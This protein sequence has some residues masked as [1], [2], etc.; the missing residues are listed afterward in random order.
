MNPYDNLLG[1]IMAGMPK[2]DIAPATVEQRRRRLE[3]SLAMWGD[4]ADTRARQARTA[5][6][7]DRMRVEDELERGCETAFEIRDPMSDDRNIAWNAWIS[8]WQTT[9]DPNEIRWLVQEVLAVAE[10]EPKAPP[11]QDSEARERLLK[12]TVQLVESVCEGVEHTRE[13][14]AARAR[15]F[16]TFSRLA[17]ATAKVNSIDAQ[18][19]YDKYLS[20]GERRIIEAVEAGDS[21]ARSE[22]VIEQVHTVAFIGNY[23][24][25]PNKEIFDSRRFSKNNNLPAGNP[26]TRALMRDMAAIVPVY[27][28]IGT[29]DED[30][31]GCS[32]SFRIWAEHRAED[33]GTTVYCGLDAKTGA[34]MAYDDDGSNPRPPEQVAIDPEPGSPVFVKIVP[35]A[36]PHDIESK[37]R[38]TTALGKG[39]Y[40]ATKADMHS[41]VTACAA[42]LGGPR[43]VHVMLSEKGQSDL[44]HERRSTRVGKKTT[45]PPQIS[46]AHHC[47][48][49]GLSLAGHP[50]DYTFGAPLPAKDR[51][52][53]ETGE[54]L[55]GQGSGN[56]MD[57]VKFTWVALGRESSGKSLI[58]GRT[59]H[60]LAALETRDAE[61]RWLNGAESRVPQV[62]PM[63][64]RGD[65]VVTL[66][67]T[68]VPKT[69]PAWQVALIA[70]RAK[71]S[72]IRSC[73]N[74][75]VNAARGENTEWVD[76]ERHARVRILIDQESFANSA[77]MER[78]RKVM[79]VINSPQTRT[80]EPEVYLEV[81][82]V[83]NLAEHTVDLALIGAACPERDAPCY[84]QIVNLLSSRCAAMRIGA[85]PDGMVPG[86]V[87]VT[88]RRK[89]RQ[90][91][92]RLD[93][94]ELL[95]NDFSA[96]QAA[97]FIGTGQKL[98]GLGAFRLNEDLPVLTESE[99]KRA[100]AR[101]RKLMLA[102]EDTIAPGRIE[103]IIGDP[104]AEKRRELIQQGRQLPFEGLRE[105][106]SQGIDR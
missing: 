31:D 26:G 61:R 84:D 6:G 43:H 47:A 24:F 91:Q 66:R 83:D 29:P 15:R 1:P 3:N 32:P 17:R 73:L 96:P 101:V 19:G 36:I 68:G 78:V 27:E 44:Y 12:A 8:E 48:L 89:D 38:M 93:D 81:A 103:S 57:P 82:C 54:Y 99:S 88:G 63:P 46:I 80:D 104:D 55:I 64:K 25:N 52:G 74:N 76:P 22:P 33:R 39:P 14:R 77:F 20:E 51:H 34:V 10:L 37:N 58:A 92:W 16:H 41:V 42:S 98:P 67:R 30:A 85:G 28:F 97:A 9:G 40:A 21:T 72:E 5:S 86:K 59:T 62:A 69:Y 102:T 100:I 90:N 71:D 106:R 13:A 45:Y 75:V 94:A 95:K 11:R 50:L 23:P 65:P 105:Q 4:E 60:L 79:K 56:T 49:A 7:R 18:I 87:C 53:Q 35:C 70:P 2:I